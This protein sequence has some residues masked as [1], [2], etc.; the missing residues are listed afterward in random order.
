MDVNVSNLKHEL[1][2]TAP[3]LIGFFLAWGHEGLFR[4]LIHCPN[5][6]R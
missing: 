6:F 2:L 4:G 3:D 5:P 1:S